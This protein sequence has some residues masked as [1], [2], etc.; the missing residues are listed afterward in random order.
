MRRALGLLLLLGFGLLVF[1]ITREAYRPDAPS[2]QVNSTVLLERVHPVLKL[3]TVEGEFSEL[4][5]YRNA[6]AT[7]EWLE[8]FPI[9]QK[10]AILRVKAR[11]SV[12]YDLEGLG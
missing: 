12:G 3:V 10:R 2:E 11:A 4:Y 8:Q 6:D 9:F 5:T 1:F 7:F